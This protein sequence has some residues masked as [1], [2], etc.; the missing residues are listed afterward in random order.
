VCDSRNRCGWRGCRW[1]R[2]QQ[3]RSGV[4]DD[5]TAIVS[6]CCEFCRC[7]S[8]PSPMQGAREG[9]QLG[10][11]PAFSTNR[12]GRMHT[13]ADIS[14]N[15]TCHRLRGVPRPCS[16]PHQRLGV[17]C[18]ALQ[19]LDDRELLPT[20]SPLR[21]KRERARPVAVWRCH[22]DACQVDTNHRAKGRT[23]GALRSTLR[24]SWECKASVR[25]FAGI[26]V[27]LY[28]RCWLLQVRVRCGDFRNAAWRQRQLY[29]HEHD[30]S[31]MQQLDGE[32]DTL[33]FS[34]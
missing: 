26:L 6:P 10:N 20:A 16:R 29:M 5:A 19:R 1:G 32:V 34:C 13:I 30:R 33:C 4:S 31:V 7:D 21:A 3:P 2:Q 15:R 22:R 17:P 9:Q 28:S 14:A 18:T 23:M 27:G 8:R 12:V 24:S 25:Q 11:T